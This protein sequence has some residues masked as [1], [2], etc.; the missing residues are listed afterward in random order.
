[1]I[2]L[3]VA[4]PRNFPN[5][6]ALN[7]PLPVSIKRLDLSGGLLLLLA[8]T[9]HITALEHAA[10]LYSW[11]SAKVLAPLVIS[12]SLWVGSFTS[13][14]YGTTADSQNEMVF[15][16]R[17]CQNRIFIGL[18]LYLVTWRSKSR[19]GTTLMLIIR[20]TFF[21]GSITTTCIIQ[22]PLRYQAASGSSPLQASIRLIPFMVTIQVGG[23]LVAALAT[24]RRMPP[25]YLSFLGA[26]CQLFGC[27]V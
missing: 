10:N 19:M 22:I 9:L 11:R 21:T 7:K 26:I 20:N 4:M 1:M 24:K 17:F 15:P 13:Q 27:I 8:M 2:L 23:M 14:W 12:V 6:G 16:W 18:L 3:A 5:Q 25:V